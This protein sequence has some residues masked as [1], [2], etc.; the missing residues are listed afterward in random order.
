VYVGGWAVFSRLNA[1]VV[2]VKRRKRALRIIPVQYYASTRYGPLAVPGML[3]NSYAVEL[4]YTAIKIIIKKL[5]QC[6]V[7]YCI[8]LIQYRTRAVRSCHLFAVCKVLISVPYRHGGGVL[9]IND[10]IKN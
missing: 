8:I 4:Y 2:K 1:S 5:Y 6:Q 7:R 10:S 3:Y 9:I